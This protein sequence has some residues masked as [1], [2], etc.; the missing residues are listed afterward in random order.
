MGGCRIHA[1]MVEAGQVRQHHAGSCDPG[2]FGRLVR[3]ALVTELTISKPSQQLRLDEGD[4]TDDWRACPDCARITPGAAGHAGTPGPASACAG[5]GAAPRAGDGV[6]GW[7][8][9]PLRI[10][11][12]QMTA[13]PAKIAAVH[14]N[15]VV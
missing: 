14:Q 5:A 1:A 12:P 7:A 10:R 9:G 8:S 15:A 3:C 11:A 2:M 4:I 6:P 13:P